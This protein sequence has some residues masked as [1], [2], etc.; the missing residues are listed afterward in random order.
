MNTTQT[1]FN[2]LYSK[3]TELETHKVELSIVDD[4]KKESDKLSDRTLQFEKM[5]DDI[6]K[7]RIRMLKAKKTI[8][9]NLPKYNKVIDST[10]KLIS[11]A[12]SLLS[13]S[14]K[15]AK[16]LGLDAKNIQGYG[17]L[18]RYIKFLQENVRGANRFVGQLEDLI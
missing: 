1:V 7:D 17:T 14:E 6:D 18:K 2:K 12:E 11:S 3:K 9:K 5:L 8:E 16:D 4:I 15:A 13:K 10:P